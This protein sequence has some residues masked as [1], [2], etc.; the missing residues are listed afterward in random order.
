VSDPAL[1]GLLTAVAEGDLDAVLVL[2]DWLE[3]RGDPRAEG[4]RRLHVLLYD[5]WLYAPLSF[6]V[7]RVARQEVWPLFPE[8]REPEG[9]E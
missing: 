4:V 9:P 6:R 3:E 7:Q 1:T 2:S 8:H 5:Y